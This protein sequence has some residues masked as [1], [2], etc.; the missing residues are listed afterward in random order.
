MKEQLKERPVRQYVAILFAD[1][2][3][4]SRLMNKN[5]VDTYERVALSIDMMKQLIED[6]RGNVVQI[7]GDGIYA[8]FSEAK[9][10]LTF[11]VEVQREFR[12]E[13]VWNV[14]GDPITFRIGINFGS[15]LIN[16]SGARGHSV[17]VA[18][19]IQALA[20]PGGIC[21]SEVVRQAIGEPIDHPMRSLGSR[22]LKN[23]DE[24][25]EVF[26]IELNGEQGAQDVQALPVDD[27]MEIP[28]QTSVTVLPF[29]N[30]SGDPRDDHLCNGLTGDI[31]TNLCKFRDLFVIAHHSASMLKQRQLPMTEI[32]ARLGVRYLL[33]GELQRSE[34]RIR[35]RVTLVDSET[36]SVIWSDRYDGHLT[37]IFAFQD[38]VT[39]LIAAR[40]AIQVSAAEGRRLANANPPHIRA[41]GLII[42]GQDLYY[43]YRR[44]SNLHARRLFEQAATIDPYYGRSYAGI[45]RTFNLA[46]RYRWTDSPEEALDNAVDLALKAIRYDNLDARGYGALGFAQLYKKRHDECLAAYERAIELNPNDADLLAEMGDALAY[47]EQPERGVE[48]L[49]RA[50]RLNPYHPDWYLWNLGDAHFFSGHYEAA[51]ATLKK[52]RDQ[53]QAHRLLASCYAHLGH[54]DEA[55]FHAREILKSQPDF[56]I[57]F[58]RDVPP[59][60]NAKDNEIFFEG[61]RKA[62]LR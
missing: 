30:L 16:R 3:G 52:M 41:Y 59:N 6:Y 21:I 51:I 37:E 26:A 61:L 4:Y 34:A 33:K 14:D 57:A 32:G 48:M 15:V 29:D 55:S 50:I 20:R 10:A 45:S 2:V 12:K 54:V 40:L 24:A 9:D 42:R 39:S 11:A 47:A 43:R 36:A 58:W 27:V 25:V 18:A 8:L 31:T 5:E 56:S 13:A 38:D 62:G 49:E 7:V 17:N 28:N 22:N 44:E 53:S 46:W 23:I 60:K 19:R 35:L 1:I